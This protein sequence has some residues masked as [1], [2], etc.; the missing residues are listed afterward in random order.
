MIFGSQIPTFATQPAPGQR[1]YAT[2]PGV[3]AAFLGDSI[4]HGSNAAAGRR[5]VDQLPRILGTSLVSSKSMEKGVP[6]QTSAQM[7]ARYA[8]DVRA[9][10]AQ[11]LFLLAG[12]NDANQ[13]VPLA[14]YAANIKA[15]VAEARKDGIPVIIGTVPPFGASA[16]TTAKSLLVA[17]YNAWINAWAPSNGVRV[18]A[19]N[20]GLVASGAETMLSGYDSGDG[21]HPETQGHQK[22]AQAFATAFNGLAT[23]LHV[24]QTVT[25]FNMISNPLF[26]SNYSGP[27]FEQSG[28]TGTAPTVSVA[29]DTTGTLAAGQWGTVAWNATTGGTRYRVCTLTTGFAPGDTL[30]VTAR[31]LITDIGG[32]YLT[33]MQG[34]APTADFSVRMFK[35]SDMTTLYNF[36]GPSAVLNPGPICD[37]FTVPAATTSL[38]FGTRMTIP[39]GLNVNFQIGE[40]GVFNVTGL[41]D[42]LGL[43]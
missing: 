2:A 5:W 21:I 1:P 16:V 7:L 28:G 29:A 10:G 20:A 43:V 13:G 41:T 39:T 17:Q 22:I 11:V 37:L 23:P 14:T 9:N 38:T 12:T 30:L 4:T 32:G 15:I 33:A 19:V 18:A 35:S 24:V 27:W 6:G 31:T 40:V 36:N 8:T 26:L 42:L 34:A 25:A 3:K